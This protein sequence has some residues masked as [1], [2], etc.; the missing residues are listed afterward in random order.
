MRR[1]YIATFGWVSGGHDG[2][3]SV[4]SLI[5]IEVLRGQSQIFSGI[6]MRKDKTR[7]NI[8]EYT[9]K[10]LF[11]HCFKPSINTPGLNNSKRAS[12]AVEWTIHPT[13]KPKK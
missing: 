13:A 3:L 11:Y 10:P 2:N 8:P 4:Y 6:F 5:F 12:M 7:A 1:N 9:S